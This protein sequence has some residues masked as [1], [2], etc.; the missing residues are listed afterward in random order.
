MQTIQKIE[1]TQNSISPPSRIAA[2]EQG[3]ARVS[4]QAIVES[5]L[6]NINWARPDRGYCQCPG[7]ESHTRSNGRRDCCVMLNRVPTVY[8]VHTSCRPRIEQIN[9]ALRP[10]I[11]KGAAAFN[12]CRPPASDLLLHPD[13]QQSTQLPTHPSHHLPLTLH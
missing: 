1:N 2:P 3:S 10:A 12:P 9:P 6:G 4:S 13:P 11:C 7:R 8:C 5:L